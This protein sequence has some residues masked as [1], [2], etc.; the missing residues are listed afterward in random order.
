MD[1]ITKIKCVGNLKSIDFNPRRNESAK[2]YA[3]ECFKK[4]WHILKHYVAASDHNL[5]AYK[6]ALEQS[7]H[8]RTTINSDWS[9]VSPCWFI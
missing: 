4:S 1:S 2:L 8:S 9:W 5:F 6:V 7:E 3:P